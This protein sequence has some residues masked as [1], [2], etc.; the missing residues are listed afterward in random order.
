MSDRRAAQAARLHRQREFAAMWVERLIAFLDATQPDP[1]LE[2]DD[3]P[4]A[5]GDEGDYSC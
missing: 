3:P 2:E 5:V 4:E 1:D